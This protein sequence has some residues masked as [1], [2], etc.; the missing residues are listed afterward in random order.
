MQEHQQNFTHH[1]GGSLADLVTKFKADPE[2]CE[3]LV[4][5]ALF[6]RT[7]TLIE[8]HKQKVWILKS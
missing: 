7:E 2:K 6:F 1:F 8:E 5:L 3:D 4:E